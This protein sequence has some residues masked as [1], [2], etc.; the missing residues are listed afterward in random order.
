MSH[1]HDCTMVAYLAT[2]GVEA[3]PD[4]GLH[5]DPDQYENLVAALAEGDPAVRDVITAMVTS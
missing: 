1:E 2:R 5:I 4:R 3:S